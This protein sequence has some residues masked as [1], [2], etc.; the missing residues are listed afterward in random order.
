MFLGEDP[1]YRLT[2]LNTHG[3][4]VKGWQSRKNCEYPQEIVLH[5]E[6]RCVLNKIQILAHQYMIRMYIWIIYEFTVLTTLFVIFSNGLIFVYQVYVF[7][8]K[9]MQMFIHFFIQKYRKV[10][11]PLNI[12]LILVFLDS[13]SLFTYFHYKIEARVYYYYILFFT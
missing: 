4:I 7:F 5:L 6:K 11:F 13:T 3:P 12:L 10:K 2:E 9:N 8:L 1:K